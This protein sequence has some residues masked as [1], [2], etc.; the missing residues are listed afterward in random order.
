MNGA[1]PL[2]VHE[3]GTLD[4][5]DILERIQE[6]AR[7]GV[8][9]EHMRFGVETSIG[10]ILGQALGEPYGRIAV[11]QM[12]MPFHHDMELFQHEGMYHFV[13]EHLLELRIGSGERE[14]DRALDE[15]RETRGRFG[16]EIRRDVRFLEVVMRSSQNDGDPRFEIHRKE[17]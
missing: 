2:F 9:E 10:T 12:P 14:R 11:I 3:V 4:P 5:P 6:I 8:A 7:H 13:A 16:H 15:F 17:G 1:F